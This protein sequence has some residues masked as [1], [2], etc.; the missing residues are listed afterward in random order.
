MASTA[1]IPNDAPF[2]ADTVRHV[3]NELEHIRSSRSG[4]GS[5]GCT[6]RKLTVYIPPPN[7][8]KKAQHKR[9]S[10]RR[11]K[12]ELRKRGLLTATVQQRYKSRAEL[13]QYL[14]DVVEKEPCCWNADDCPCLQGGLGCQADCCDCWKDSH[15]TKDSTTTAVDKYQQP[16]ASTNAIVQRCGNRHGMYVVDLD[17]IQDYRRNVLTNLPLYCGVINSE[18][19][20]DHNNK[21]KSGA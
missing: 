13:E 18:G 7:S 5:T 3:R 10:E 19:K 9:L 12:E 8:G 20:D 21:N 4:E 1:N 17:A 14:H 15:Q 16:L 6:C 2:D 11:V